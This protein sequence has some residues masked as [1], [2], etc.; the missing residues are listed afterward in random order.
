MFVFPERTVLQ[1]VGALE[2]LQQEVLLALTAGTVP[3]FTAS[4]GVAHSSQAPSLEEICRIADGALYRA[5]R[6][7]RDRVVANEVFQPDLN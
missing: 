6:E 5:K 4:F 7:G 2:R 1:A 3:G